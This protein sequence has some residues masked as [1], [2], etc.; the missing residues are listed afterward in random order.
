MCVPL[1]LLEAAGTKD[2]PIT[3]NVAPDPNAEKKIRYD[4]MTAMHL[5]LEKNVLNADEFLSSVEYVDVRGGIEW[6]DVLTPGNSTHGLIVSRRVVESWINAG[7]EG[8]SLVPR[9]IR[10]VKS[11]ALCK[12]VAP[13]YF[14]VIAKGKILCRYRF[15]E[16]TSDGYQFRFETENP[17]AEP[18]TRFM[19]EGY[20]QYHQLVPIQ[21]SWDGGDLIC[22][23]GQDRM[24]AFGRCFCSRRIVEVAKERQLSNFAF[25]PMD[26]VERFGGDFR[27]LPWPPEIWYKKDNPPSVFLSGR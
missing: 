19:A 3:V 6:S 23:P 20:I 1:F 16:K 8:F 12:D 17:S 21:D 9:V 4:E 11:S 7:V 26:A 2:A 27:D 18:R 14:E 10:K 24:G 5:M 25:S 15:F 13:L 22:L